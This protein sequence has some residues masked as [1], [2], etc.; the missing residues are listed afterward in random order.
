LTDQN[1]FYSLECTKIHYQP[2]IYFGRHCWA[3]DA[4]L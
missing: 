4:V 2:G 1:G 3:N